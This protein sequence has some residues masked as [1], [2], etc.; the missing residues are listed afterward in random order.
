MTREHPAVGGWRATLLKAALVGLIAMSGCERQPA[1]LVDPDETYAQIR[2][3]IRNF[4]ISNE[5]F[6]VET[7]AFTADF[8]ELQSEFEWALDSV[9]L[10]V[11]VTADRQGWSVVATHQ[12]AGPDVG[13]VLVYGNAPAE[14][15]GGVPWVPHD[16]GHLIVCDDVFDAVTDRPGLAPSRSA[17]GDP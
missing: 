13:C 4:A 9:E 8:N 11:E 12:R 15:P 7:G 16:G 10:K 1:R 6:S 3:A 14:T 2:S 5:F 17:D